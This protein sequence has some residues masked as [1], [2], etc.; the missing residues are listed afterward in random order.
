MA[1]FRMLADWTDQSEKTT[2]KAGPF[3]IIDEGK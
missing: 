2:R 3:Q 1:G